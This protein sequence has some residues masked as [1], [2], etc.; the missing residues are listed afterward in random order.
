MKILR[1]LAAGIVAIAVTFVGAIASD[2]GPAPVSFEDSAEEYILSRLV[3][4]R[5]V[6]FK[7]AGEPYQVFA[8][9][10]S[11]EGLSGW[12]VDVRVKARMPSGSFGGYIP[13][14][15]IFIDGDPVAFEEDT[16][17]LTRL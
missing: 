9:I 8:D 10:G 7:F 12:A 14:T 5:G 4:P 2:F 3:D 17:Q 6:R 15:V 1:S 13:Y 11:Y 16:G